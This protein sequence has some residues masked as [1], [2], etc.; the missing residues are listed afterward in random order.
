MQLHQIKRKTKLT[1]KRQI[2]RGGKR[3]TTAG[4]GTKGQKARSGHRI[5]PEIRDA[6]KKIPK[7]RGR[8]KNINTSIKTK[9]LIV[10]LALL[11]KAFPN[12]G[13]VTPQALIEAKV[14]RARGGGRPV[15]KILAGG[16]LKVKLN[17]SG[18]QLSATARQAIEQAGG[19]VK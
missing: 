3:G 14:V 5:R 1:K 17:V 8:G 9:A 10:S 16:E 2:G 6:I 19:T 12:G 4:R 7:M 11:A 13:T 15:V 18:C